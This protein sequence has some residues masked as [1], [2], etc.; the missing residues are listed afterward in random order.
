MINPQKPVINPIKNCNRFTAL[1]YIYI[2]III[3]I[4][5]IQKYK[6]NEIRNK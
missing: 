1:I 3:L 4:I 5:E 6:I 2:I